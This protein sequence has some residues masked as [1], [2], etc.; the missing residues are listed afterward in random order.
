VD[1]VPFHF[2]LSNDLLADLVFG[3]CKVKL[4]GDGQ[5]GGMCTGFACR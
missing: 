4:R 1:H 5:L 3:L 2:E